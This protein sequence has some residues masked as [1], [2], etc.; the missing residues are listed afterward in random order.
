VLWLPPPHWIN[1]S[2]LVLWMFTGLPALR[3]YYQF[4][5]DP[6]C[7]KF[8]TMV[9]LGFALLGLEI[10]ICIKFSR[11]MFPKPIPQEV[12]I[13][14]AVSLTLLTLG[15]VCFFIFKNMREVNKQKTR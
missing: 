10:L 7:K 5:T 12:I 13:S 6:T 2:R 11:G 4:V 15:T 1:V 14:W 3:E 9:W 8:G